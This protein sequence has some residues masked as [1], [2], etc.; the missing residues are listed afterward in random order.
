MA[1]GKRSSQKKDEQPEL[2]QDALLEVLGKTV[3][4]VQIDAGTE[5][6]GR[7]IELV[8]APDADPIVASLHVVERPDF[9]PGKWGVS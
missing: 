5:V 2:T 8:T 7:A 3:E 4:P 1:T 9:P 6:F